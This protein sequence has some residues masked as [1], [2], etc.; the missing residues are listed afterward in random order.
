MN[1]S[2]D[3]EGNGKAGLTFVLEA[4]GDAKQRLVISTDRLAEAQLPNFTD[5]PAG[6]QEFHLAMADNSK[7]LSKAMDASL[8]WQIIQVKREQL[9]LEAAEHVHRRITD[10]PN[11]SFSGHDGMD[12]R[13][14]R[15]GRDA[16][17]HVGKWY[18]KG[19]AAVWPF[20]IIGVA[21]I[22]GWVVLRLKG[23]V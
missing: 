22:I 9:R 18:A 6:G 10:N 7:A 1:G 20:T 8:Q 23:V 13:D 11:A 4:M 17:I 3:I 2:P 21:A 16:E 14:G 19:A 12:G 15:D 5:C